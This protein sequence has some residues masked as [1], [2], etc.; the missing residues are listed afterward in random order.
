MRAGARGTV[1]FENGGFVR[2]RKKEWVQLTLQL[3]GETLRLIDGDSNARLTR[4]RTSTR[5]K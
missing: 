5:P 2:G 4:K 1:L 3:R